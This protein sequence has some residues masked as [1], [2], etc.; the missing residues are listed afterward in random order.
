MCCFVI[1]V[2]PFVVMEE[3]SSPQDN[4]NKKKSKIKITHKPKRLNYWLGYLFLN[5]R[6]FN[7]KILG[8]H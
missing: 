3:K 2:H 4:N 5:K 6:E 8:Y 7:K 1:P